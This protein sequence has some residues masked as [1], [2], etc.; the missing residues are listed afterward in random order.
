MRPFSC[1]LSLRCVMSKH[2]DIPPSP[3]SLIEALRD[4]GYSIETAIADIIDN[5]ITANALKI[6]IRFSWNSGGTWLAIIDDGDGM[7]DDELQ[8]AMRFGSTNPL[9]NRAENDL[10]RFGLGM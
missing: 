6:Q 7:T 9:K 5:S 1:L 3:A 2:I 4:I 10:G 8:N